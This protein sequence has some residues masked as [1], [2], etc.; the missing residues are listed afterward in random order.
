M[1]FGFLPQIP[2]A[3][4]EAVAFSMAGRAAE[5]EGGP[6][7]RLAGFRRELYGCFT[8]R[9]DALFELADAV[10]CTDG[11]VRSL[12][13]LSLCPVF[14]RGHGALYDALACGG[15]DEDRLRDALIG[16]LPDGLPLLF[17]V[18]V[19]AFPR[20]DAACSPGRVHCYACC[21]CDGRRKTI[22][23]WNYS[24]ITGVDWGTSSW[25]YPVDAVR[26]AAGDDQVAVTAAQVRALVGRLE[27]A[28]RCGAR[29][30]PVPMMIFDGGYS[31]PALTHALDGTAVQ[32]LVRVRDEGRRVFYGPP[33]PPVPGR[34]G[35]PRRH[36]ARFKLAE[37]GTWPAPDQVLIV[38]DSG[39]YGRVEVRAWHGLHQKLQ[40]R[41]H[42]GARP[43]PASVPGTIIQVSAERLPDGRTPAGPMWL[44]WAAPPGM[45][46]DLDLIWRAYL[47]RFDAEHGFRFDKGTLGWT[48]ARVRTPEQADLWT[49]LILAAYTQLHLARQLAPGL[50]R[51]WERPPRP[52]HGLSPA[53]VRRGFRH[54]RDQIGTP[55]RGPKP[56]RPGPGRPKGSTAGPA[57]RYPVLKK[58]S[59]G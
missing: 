33:P 31:A 23:G 42:F 24:R 9:A 10:L 58:T 53:R 52:G 32:V 55:A 54:I 16:A 4:A 3:K 37:A 25:V 45:A 36:G 11:P 17:A 50:R 7:G 2:E 48:C 14:R 27:K 8:A 6:A 51:P 13:E 28:G 1:I 49:W 56:A 5:V 15:I 46:C 39:R 34:P 57:P 59:R 44:W 20:P 22:P 43:Q 41:G 40:G 21:R 26:L 35:R 18:D 12:A 38:A 29:G 30:Q 47:R 19:T